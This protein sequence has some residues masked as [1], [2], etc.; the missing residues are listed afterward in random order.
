MPGWRVDDDPLLPSSPAG[1]ARPAGCG[2]VR[3]SAD[4]APSVNRPGRGVAR[5]HRPGDG[6]AR[7][8]RDAAVPGRA[9]SRQTGPLLLGAGR[10]AP[11]VRLYRTGGTVSR[12]ALRSAWGGD[13]RTAGGHDPGPAR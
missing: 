11:R 6:R 2:A 4:A 10:I 12:A 3:L 13:H 5:G 9:V 1:C 7:R 8:L